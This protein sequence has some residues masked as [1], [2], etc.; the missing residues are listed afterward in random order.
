[1]RAI[2]S[3]DR[4]RFAACARRAAASGT[5]T[6]GCTC[7]RAAASTTTAIRRG[8]RTCAG[9]TVRRCGR[10][11]GFDASD[12]DDDGI[13]WLGNGLRFTTSRN[14]E[15]YG[16][17]LEDVAYVDLLKKELARREK[18]A[19]PQYERLVSDYAAQ[20]KKPDQTQIDAWRLSVG[21]AI[22]GLRKDD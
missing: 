11:D 7:I 20:T 17:G 12:G 13:L 18:G 6:A 9:W 15:A 2:R 4:R 19:F 22:H 8:S 10:A 21:R 16:Q 5:T 3:A 1:M 14:F